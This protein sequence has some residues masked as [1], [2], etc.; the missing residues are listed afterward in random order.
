MFRDSSRKARRRKLP[1]SGAMA[2]ANLEEILLNG[3]L[4]QSRHLES[5]QRSEEATPKARALCAPIRH[6]DRCCF[7]RGGDSPRPIGIASRLQLGSR[8]GSSERPSIDN[9]GKRGQ[10]SVSDI[11]PEPATLVGLNPERRHQLSTPQVSGEK[12]ERN[13]EEPEP[14]IPETIKSTNSFGDKTRGKTKN[15]PG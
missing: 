8:G 9:E 2:M 1:R 3:R 14:L 7:S 5:R 13:Q 12:M 10:K 15:K 11:M 4:H 6:R